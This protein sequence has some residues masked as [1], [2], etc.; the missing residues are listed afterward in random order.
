MTVPNAFAAVSTATGAQLDANFA[1]CLQLNAANTLTNQLNY[2]PS[3]VIASASTVNIGAAASNNITISGTATINA[4]DTIAEGALRYVTYSGASTLTYNVTSMQ[5]VGAANRTVASGDF[6]LFRSLGS[7]NWREEIYLPAAGYVITGQGGMVTGR[8]TV[9]AGPTDVNGAPAFLPQTV[10]GL[11]LTTLNIAANATMTAN[12]T[13]SNGSA[14]ITWTSHTLAI[15]KAVSFTTSGTLPTNFSPATVYYVVAA[16]FAANTFSVSATPGG[17][18]IS[19]GSAGTGT[20]T[21]WAGESNILTVSAQSGF[22]ISGQ[23]NAVGLSSTNLTWTGLTNTATNY[24]YV[25]VSNGVNTTGFTT[26]API[27]QYESISTPSITSGQ[28]TINLATGITYLGSGASA[29]VTPLVVIGTATTSGGNITST[30]AYKFNKIQS[31][32]VAFPAQQGA[33]IKFTTI[34]A[35][36]ASWAPDPA[37]TRIV[38][39][40]IGGGGPGGPGGGTSGGSG[41][42]GGGGGGGG[43]IV[44]AS[45]S[46]VL[47]SY[48]VTIGGSGSSTSFGALATASA[49]VTGAGIGTQVFTVETL[50]GPG[51]TGGGY[52]GGAGGA[53]GLAG[54]AGTANTGGGGGGGGGGS[55]ASAAGGAGGS[56]VI[57]VWEY[58]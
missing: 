3:V 56:G 2:A 27:V 33:L 31:G 21:A 18:A 24:L 44:T 55:T 9:L 22:S 51:G 40:C 29:V 26:L 25:T 43:A 57:Y 17:T 20:Q 7:G 28:I 50:R 30:T 35:S 46:A 41:A 49:G 39:M 11:N 53:A 52:G 42:V 8:Q 58:A 47:P 5:L 23:N 16:N 10:T 38:V 37:T 32:A 4:F 54:N 6:S 45:T 14:V 36:N 12:V 34:T 48:A 15:G 1:A 13:F 19:A